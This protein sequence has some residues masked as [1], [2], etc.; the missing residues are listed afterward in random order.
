MINAAATISKATK[1]HLAER[2]VA[3]SAFLTEPVELARSEGG[4]V[5]S[6][7]Q[8]FPKGPELATMDGR[9]FKLSD[10]D[11]FVAA[12]NA[13]GRPV[14]VDYD[15]R[16]HFT[17]DDGGSDRA[18]GWIERLAV[19]D[20]AVWGEVEWTEA[21]K[22]AIAAKEYRFIS[23]EFPTEPKT[24]EV[25]ALLAAALVNRPA[26]DMAALTR[27]QSQTGDTAML[28]AIAKAL[29]LAEDADEAAILA[30]IAKK[31]ADHTAELATAK[32]KAGRPSTDD[33]M[34]RADYDAV[35][36]RAETAEKKLGD[37]EAAAFEEKVTSAI[38]EAVE[39]GKIT[40]GTKDHYVALCTDDKALEKV[41]AAI[42]A[43]PKVTDKT[44]ITGKPGA[45][46]EKD[47]PVALASKARVYQKQQLDIGNKITIADAVAAVEKGQAT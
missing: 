43:A 39:A 42:G 29:G 12:F 35:L 17:V 27:T 7:I 9:K 22:A 36:A 13:S 41:L 6:L 16:S 26:F 8:L 31:D 21:A 44:G 37:A 23:P 38:D 14:M 2:T 15:H 33:F 10:P 20:G 32:S 40:P 18:A 47:D 5:P 46:G 19:K 28:T 3:R 11:A 1:R 4:Q 25:T 30:A 24:D 45:A 34:P